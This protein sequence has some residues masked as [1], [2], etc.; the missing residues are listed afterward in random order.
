[1][2]VEISYMSGA[3][4]LF[5]VIDNDKYNFTADFGSKL[6]PR[7][8][9]KSD[10]NSFATEG[11][12]LISRSD[13]NTESDFST[14]FYNPDGSCDAMCGN[15]GRCAVHFATI[16][17]INRKISGKFSMAG[18]F[19]KYKFSKDLITLFFPA[20]AAFKK[21]FYVQT[22]KI[23]FCG[24][25][26]DVGTR[27]FIIDSD[28]Y[29]DSADFCSA[30]I[31]PVAKLIRYAKEFSPHGV[32]VNF[33]KITDNSV[34]L[35]TFERGVEA[36]TGAC[37]TGTLSTAIALNSLN[38]TQFPVK[39]IPTSGIPLFVDKNNDSEY[40]LTGPAEVLR[41]VSVNI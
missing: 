23:V 38:L 29:L 28:A 4:N 30:D 10:V 9:R 14:I 25:Y 18:K 32:N 8:C 3:G 12:M 24:T 20:P 16:N 7:L 13:E 1:M 27:H 5:T 26:V 33:Y 37:G 22:D 2:E 39:I 6:A 40:E 21:H 19:Y 15:G 35:R 36:E 11:L 31:V 41:T 34:F 17:G